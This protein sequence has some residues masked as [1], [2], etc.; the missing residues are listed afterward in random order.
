M[1]L[2]LCLLAAALCMLWSTGILT[3]AAVAAGFTRP[4]SALEALAII[5]LGAQLSVLRWHLLLRWQMVPLQFREV[6]QISYISWFLGSFL[7][8]A[9]GADALRGLYVHRASPGN[10]LPALLTVALDRLLGLA[11]ILILALILGALLPAAVLAH[12]ALG[13]LVALAGAGLLLLVL[14]ML[15]APWLNR[16]LA[17]LLRPWPRLASMARGVGD[18]LD[19]CLAGWR[20]RPLRLVTCLGLGVVGHVAVVLAIVT[21]ALGPQGGG[22]GTVAL[23]LAGTLAVLAN[24]L[25]LTPGGIGVGEAS[26]AGIIRLLEPGADLAAYGAALFAFR[27]VTLL[28]YLPGAVAFAA[29]RRKTRSSAARTESTSPASSAE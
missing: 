9:A 10:R 29:Y 24:Q 12:P 2:K 17:P 25:P 22:P 23:G 18:A 26:F 3:P 21:L 6:W 13:G 15:L 5:M 7:P 8:G 16:R 19:E 14:S 1:L 28:S 27:L 4:G 20:Q 11:A